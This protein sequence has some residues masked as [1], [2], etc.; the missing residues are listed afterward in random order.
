MDVCF[1]T[2]NALEEAGK[3]KEGMT[4]VAKT[5]RIDNTEGLHLRPATNLCTLAQR[6]DCEVHFCIRN[7]HANAKS[8]LSVLAGMVKQGDEVTFECNGVDEQDALEAIVNLVERKM[9]LE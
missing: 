4:M 2:E 9:D 3:R 8:V 5:V 7:Y 1:E 6:Y